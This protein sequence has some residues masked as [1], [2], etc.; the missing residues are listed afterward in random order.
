[1]DT[2][3]AYHVSFLAVPSTALLSDEQFR[4]QAVARV[5]AAGM[6]YLADTSVAHRPAHSRLGVEVS[7]LSTYTVQVWDLTQSTKAKPLGKFS[8]V[9]EAATAEECLADL[10]EKMGGLELLSLAANPTH[11]ADAQLAS[12]SALTAAA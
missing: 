12:Y 6:Q 11:F 10:E 3:A 9:A 8:L 4:Q 2:P 7:A 1:M 5:W